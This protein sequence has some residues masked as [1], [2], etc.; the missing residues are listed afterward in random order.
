MSLRLQT[1]KN[2]LIP[3]TTSA[4]LPDQESASFKINKS[5]MQQQQSKI[6]KKKR[7]NVHF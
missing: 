5:Y 6:D 2:Q 7:S 1:G 3:S 4:L